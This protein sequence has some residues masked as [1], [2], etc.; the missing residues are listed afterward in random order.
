MAL[1]CALLIATDSLFTGF[2]DNVENSLGRYQGDIILGMPSGGTIEDTG[3]LMTSLMEAECVEAAAPVLETQ[4]LLLAGLGKVK[5][6]QTWGVDLDQQKKV[7][8]ISEC[9][10]FQKDKTLDQISFD[11]FPFLFQP[12]RSLLL[13]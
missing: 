9:F 1:S 7:M 11:I 2:I 12:P 8:P 4:G 6:V 5:P 13:R 10:L 3:V